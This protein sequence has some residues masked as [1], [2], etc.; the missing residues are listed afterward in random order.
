MSGVVGAYEVYIR[1]IKG[2]FQCRE[3]LEGTSP[4]YKGSMRGVPCCH[5]Y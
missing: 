5:F 2:E 1:V 3:S 4:E